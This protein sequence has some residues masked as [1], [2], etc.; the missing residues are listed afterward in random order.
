[1]WQD[2]IVAEVR[3]V[4]ET[5]AARFDFEL[6]AIY[7]ALKEQEEQSQL[8]KVSFAPKRIPPTKTEVKPALA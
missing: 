3:Q 1:M 6:W 7:R 2:P 5:H 4:R 8:E